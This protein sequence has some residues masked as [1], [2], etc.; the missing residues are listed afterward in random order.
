LKKSKNG[1]TKFNCQSKSKRN[2]ATGLERKAK[3]HSQKRTG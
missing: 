3:L 2:N 1:S